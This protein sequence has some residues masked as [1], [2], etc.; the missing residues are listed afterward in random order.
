MTLVYIVNGL[1]LIFLGLFAA[2]YAKSYFEA[3]SETWTGKFV[4]ALRTSLTIAWAAIVICSS[5]TLDF[6]ESLA[7]QLQAGAG[8]Q[9]KASIDPKYISVVVVG[10]MLVTV[11]ARMRGLWQMKKPE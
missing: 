9:I 2:V 7:N 11:I 10:I 3:K 6:I 4:E 8:D 1:G 5:L